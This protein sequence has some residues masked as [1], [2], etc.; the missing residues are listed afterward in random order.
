M[1]EKQTKGCVRPTEGQIARRT[2]RL[3]DGQADRRM[4]RRTQR[5]KHIYTDR[6][7]HKEKGREAG[8]L[9]D[10]GKDVKDG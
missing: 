5:D 8:C 1:S 4:N 3:A 2:K 10:K 9:K 6:P 7:D